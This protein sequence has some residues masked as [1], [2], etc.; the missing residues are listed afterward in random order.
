VSVFVP[1]AAFLVQT[2]RFDSIILLASIPLV[3]QMI[4]L[5]LV[6]QYP[7]FDAD[8]RTGK[9]N[10]VVLLGRQASWRV[11]LLMLIIGAAAAFYGG[12][13]GLPGV[14]AMM[15]GVFLVMEALFFFVVEGHLRSKAIMFWST[16]ISCGFYILVIAMLA[17]GSVV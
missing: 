3:F 5:M 11:G 13:F 17:L 12:L 2:P 1:V 4:A 9:R 6:V 8:M 14:A 10:L 15:A 7:D 16:A